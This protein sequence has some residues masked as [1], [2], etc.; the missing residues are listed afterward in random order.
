LAGAP[1]YEILPELLFVNLAGTCFSLKRGAWSIKKG[2]EASFLGKKGVPAKCTIPK[3]PDQVFLWY[4][5][6]KYRE[7]TDP[8]QTE[9]PNWGTTL[10]QTHKE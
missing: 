9:I 4:W 3:C 7:N 2:A 6:E 5:L 1:F 10:E 8:Y